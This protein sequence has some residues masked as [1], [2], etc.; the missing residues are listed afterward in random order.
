MPVPK[1]DT[2]DQLEAHDADYE[3]LDLRD[4][5]EAQV[6]KTYERLNEGEIRLLRLLPGKTGEDIHCN[7]VIIS[8]EFKPHYEA[9]SYA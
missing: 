1:E 7:L 2:W 8:L 5:A 3:E 9:L 6:L 4:Q